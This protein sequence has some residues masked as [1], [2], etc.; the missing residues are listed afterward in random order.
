M[1]EFGYE[2]NLT[3]E[4]FLEFSKK[5]GSP[6]GPYS[7]PLVSEIS[8]KEGDDLQA[9]G[10]IGRSYPHTDL[11]WTYDSPK[12]ILM[13]CVTPPTHNDGYSTYSILD[14][15]LS[16]FSVKELESLEKDKIFIPAPYHS[17][18]TGGK[19]SI[20][21]NKG[22]HVRFNS[23]GILH[24]MTALQLRF[25]EQ[26]IEYERYITLKTGMFFLIDN[27]KCLHGRTR[28]SQSHN[29]KLLRVFLN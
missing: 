24:I 13:Y 18:F 17:S 11:A 27:Q 28:I 26:A 14:E 3:P 2:P 19:F 12:K 4:T 8:P 15:V 9:P 29:R 10:G 21:S 20:L 6:M 25:L 22:K 5:F 23:R 16:D 7:Q 1:I